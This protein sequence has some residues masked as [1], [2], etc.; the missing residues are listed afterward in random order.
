MIAG[1]SGSKFPMSATNVPLSLTFPA[2]DSLL[3]VCPVCGP[4]SHSRLEPPQVFRRHGAL[5]DREGGG[6]SSEWRKI[7]CDACERRY[8]LRINSEGWVS[9]QAIDADAPPE[10]RKAGY[11]AVDPEA[12]GWL[13]A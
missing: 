9:A 4:T 13:T 12:R 7:Q 11:S 5:H 2:P 10:V 6:G 1:P 8:M 3:W